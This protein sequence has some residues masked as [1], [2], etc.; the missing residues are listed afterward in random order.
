M[1]IRMKKLIGAI[2]T[3]VLIV[4]ILAVMT[5]TALAPPKHDET[6]I[7]AYIDTGSNDT[8]PSYFGDLP[9]EVAPEPPLP[10]PPLY[11][12]VIILDAGHS[13]RHSPAYADYVE[14]VVMLQFALMLKPL[15]EAQG[16][17][18][19]LTRSTAEDVPLPV[20]VAMINMWA[21]EAL[22]AARILDLPE[23]GSLE[24]NAGECDCEV[25]TTINDV[26]EIDRL[27]G[28]M[29]NIM[30]HSSTY[31][32]I[33]MNSPYRPGRRIHPDLKRIFELQDNPEIGNR[34]LVISLHSNATGRPINTSI[35]GASAY[36]ISGAHR[37]TSNYY[38][39]YTYSDQSYHFG[40]TLLNLISEVGFRNRGMHVGNF[41]MIRE[42][43]VPGVLVEN[44]FHTNTRDRTNLQDSVF[45]ESLAESY[46]DA[47]TIYFE[48][49]PLPRRAL[50]AQ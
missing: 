31:A 29:Q 9:E 4:G 10:L 19:H 20:R 8:I 32:G 14:H 39:G 49:L 22:R 37:N 15:L 38:A 1:N 43:N 13:E 2:S 40:D 12:R 18:V 34:F 45:L 42:H 46:L 27:R 41:F 7:A 3:L 47:I 6:T 24:C 30:D 26:E 21:L 48:E 50:I 5:P 23:D 44:G 28:I 33:Y 36:Y 35:N 16:A 11:G 25:C 17:T